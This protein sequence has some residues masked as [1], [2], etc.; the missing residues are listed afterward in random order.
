M[1]LSLRCDLS[2][3]KKPMFAA[4]A[5]R[6]PQGVDVDVERILSPYGLP[7]HEPIPPSIVDREV[8]WCIPRHLE[9]LIYVT[10]VGKTN[11]PTTVQASHGHIVRSAEC[12]YK[13]YASSNGDPSGSE[14]GPDTENPLRAGL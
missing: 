7:N 12:A 13:N 2:I 5:W 14:M 6:Q 9:L 3:I 11:Y 8:W 4:F 10:T 1:D